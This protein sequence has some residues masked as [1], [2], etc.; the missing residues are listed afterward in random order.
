M[1]LS[2]YLKANLSGLK[3][4]HRMDNEGMSTGAIEGN[5]DKFIARRMKN[6]GMSWSIQGIR[7]MLWLRIA[8]YE[9]KLDDYLNVKTDKPEPYKLSEKSFRRV[10][11]K[12]LKRDYTQYFAAGVPAL[13]GPHSSRAW[14]IRLKSIIGG[15]M[16]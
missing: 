3:T 1:K 14:A 6:Q 8:L 9:D 10:I 12:N 15:P 11:D 7:R 5:I 13:A 2:G 4:Y 16:I